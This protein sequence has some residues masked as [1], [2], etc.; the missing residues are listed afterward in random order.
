MNIAIFLP[1]WIGDIVMATPALRALRSAYPEAHLVGVMRPYV[2]EVLAGTRLLD[3][4]L[5][6]DPRARERALGSWSLVRRMRARRPEMAVLLTNSL[7][8]G[9]LAW[10]SGAKRRIGFVRYGRGML[11]TDKLYHRRE[12]KKYVPSPVLD[13]YLRLAYVAG[14]AEQ[15][16]QMELATTFADERAAETVWRQLQLPAGDRVVTFNSGGAFGAAKLWPTEYFS[17]LAERVANQLGQT[18]LVVCGPSERRIAERIVA[19][20]NHPQVKSIA[21]APLSIGLTKA[22]I[23]RSRLLVSTDSGPRH[24]AA[25]FGV[26]VITLFGPTHI[27]WS[28]NHFAQSI[29]LQEDVPCGPCQERVCPLRH[30][31]CMRELTVDRVYAT[32]AAQ[33][34]PG[35]Q[36]KAA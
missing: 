30:H 35:Q 27:A 19:G 33:L 14:C 22:C 24:F 28:E 25:A 23:R 21:E 6:Y 12:Q 31:H 17:E 2:A 5:F 10:A 11:L 26:P 32:I 18:V 20:A 9:M 3:E 36:R 29:H 7:R 34:A 4:Q 13:D 1:N 16:P 15:S 8:T